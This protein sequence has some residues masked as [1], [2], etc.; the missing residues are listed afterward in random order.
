MTVTM[1]IKSQTFLFM[2][3]AAFLLN[4]TDKTLFIY[5]GSQKINFLVLEN[6]YIADFF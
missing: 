6:C 2:I 3:F 4:V 1:M 5:S